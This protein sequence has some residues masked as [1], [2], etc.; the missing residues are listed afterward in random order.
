MRDEGGG[1]WASANFEAGGG[2][3]QNESRKGDSG[4]TVKKMKF[5]MR[6]IYVK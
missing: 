1:R 2:E 5:I 6:N 4:K 3:G